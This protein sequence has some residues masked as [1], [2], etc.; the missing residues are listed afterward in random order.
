[1]KKRAVIIEDEEV[2]RFA[3]AHLFRSRG[4]EVI[5][6]PDA[7]SFSLFSNCECNCRANQACA[8][9]VI[10]DENMPKMTGSEF[11]RQRI[12][13]GCSIPHFAVM[14]AALQE[15]G[16]GSSGLPEIRRF[17]KPIH[18]QDLIDWIEECE[19]RIDPQRKLARL[20]VCTEF[21]ECP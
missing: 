20:P 1:M 9:I 4:F 21:T 14:S 16:G 7:V 15:A 5:A 19:K 13:Q 6:C 3:V 17:E 10:T 18:I 2:I 12:H 8:D 11:I